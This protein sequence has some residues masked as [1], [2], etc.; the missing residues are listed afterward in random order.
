LNAQQRLGARTLKG[1]PL[2]PVRFSERVGKV[3][4]RPIDTPRRRRPAVVR[5]PSGK[6]VGGAWAKSRARPRLEGPRRVKPKGA[7]SFRLIN[8]VPE[9]RDSRKGQSPEAAARRAGPPLRRRDNRREKRHVG[10]TAAETR[11][12]PSGRRKLRRVNPKSA[13]GVKQ[14]RHG[15]GESKASRG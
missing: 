1:L 13:A 4:P 2:R 8:S 12:Q 10:P 3:K 5:P 6:R 11:W 14:N 9:T 15:L 7:A